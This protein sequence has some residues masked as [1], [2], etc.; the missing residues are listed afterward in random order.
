[1]NTL[2]RRL[3]SVASVFAFV[4]AASLLPA[5]AHAPV[6]PVPAPLTAEQTENN[7][8]SFDLVWSTVK[9]AHYDPTLGGIDW[10]AAKE[11][12]RPAV[13]NA[14]SM[15]D[16][17][18]AMSS[19]L[20]ELGQSHMGIVPGEAY[21]DAKSAKSGDSPHAE[22]ESGTKKPASREKGSSGISFRVI[23]DD[24]V[25]SKVRAGSPAEEAGIKTG[26]VLASAS[27]TPIAPA[28]KRLRESMPSSSEVDFMLARVAESRVNG[29]LGERVDLSFET[30]SG[31]IV[32]KSFV[33]AAPAGKM[34]S[35]MNLPPVPVDFESRRL[36][37][38]KGGS[39]GYIWFS[40]FLDPAG[41]T[42]KINEAM[43]SFKDCRGVIFDVRGNPG[44][45][46]AMSMG[47]A[48]WFVKEPKTLGEMIMRGNTLKF[49]ANPRGST[50]DGPLA[51][52]IDGSSVSTSEIFAGGM[53]DIG[54][55]RLFGTRTAG[56]ALPSVLDRL[57]NGD[58]FQYVIAN[59][60]SAGGKPLEG[61]GVTPD[62][63]V[64]L[65]R[66][67]LLQGRDNQIDSALRW[68]AASRTSTPQ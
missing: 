11:R 4:A 10:D 25:V 1:M 66:A 29:S 34:V 27:G 50:F 26:W 47:I 37:D 35:A 57:P 7:L 14:K 12:Y 24:A 33:L 67:S 6:P 17:R 40:I 28:L 43:R 52:L 23:G 38:G 30:G 16:A 51:I 39:V 19:L 15:N 59:Y 20:G 45:L 68:I 54:R 62:E 9:V 63:I 55:A 64:P 21:D 36:D 18:Q 5:C 22:R 2:F 44:G 3:A 13:A 49:I 60:I 31:S 61:D 8:K 41:L 42:P 32:S 48:G 65:D 56:A 46:G 58:G 53:K